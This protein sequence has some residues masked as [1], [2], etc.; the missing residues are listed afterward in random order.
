MVTS[1]KSEQD[2]ENLNQRLRSLKIDRGPGASPGPAN[3]S[4]TLLLLA[5]SALIALLAIG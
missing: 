5:L 2:Q 1:P 4:P 3:R